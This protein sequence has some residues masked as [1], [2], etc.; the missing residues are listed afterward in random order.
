M[1]TTRGIPVPSSA[2]GELAPE[3]R[4]STYP[5]ALHSVV[6]PPQFLADPGSREF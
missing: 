1:S 2:R 3:N 6:L 4:L 5:L